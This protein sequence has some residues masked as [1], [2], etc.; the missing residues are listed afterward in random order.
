MEPRLIVEVYCNKKVLLGLGKETRLYDTMLKLSNADIMY[1]GDFMDGYKELPKKSGDLAAMC[2]Y[3]LPDEYIREKIEDEN[4]SDANLLL[5]QRDISLGD[6][7]EA[8]LQSVRSFS[9]I[10][11]THNEEGKGFTGTEEESDINLQDEEDISP[12]TTE[13]EVLVLG[14][15]KL[16]NV[17]TRDMQKKI[18]ARGGN[19]LKAIQFLGSNLTR[20]IILYALETVITLYYKFGWRF[21]SGC[22]AIER[23]HY[24]NAVK[25]LYMFYKENG[26][27]E[28]DGVYRVGTQKNNYEKEHNALLKPFMKF[29]HSFFKILNKSTVVE[30]EETAAGLARE[31]GRDDGFRMLLC[32]D[33]N[34]FSESQMSSKRQKVGGSKED[35]FEMWVLS[36]GNDNE[37]S[38]MSNTIST[39]LGKRKRGGRKKTMKKRKKKHSTKK[40]A[41]KKRNY[42]RK[43]KKHNKTKTVKRK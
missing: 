5:I 25:D 12:E 13:M 39:Q 26:V 23:G 24:A 20:G 3:G 30:L 9:F 42:T 33:M 8:Y 36:L 18:F 17:K 27:P 6:S 34:P 11:V 4:E 29:G 38:G 22:S 1:A 43:G 28:E 35:E 31:E 40:K 41:P 14:S 15:Q 21:I 32:P 2:Q 37:Q 10:R 19:T 7:G 16:P